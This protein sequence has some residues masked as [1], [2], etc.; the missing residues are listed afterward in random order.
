MM[1]QFYRAIA[2]VLLISSVEANA[3]VVPSEY[4][5]GLQALD[6][7]QFSLALHH[8]YT[9]KLQQQHRLALKAN[10]IENEVLNRFIQ[11]AESKISEIEIADKLHS[12]EKGPRK[13][14]AQTTE[15]DTTEKRKINF[16][17]GLDFSKLYR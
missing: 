8:F 15:T 5:L 11:F 13:V 7:S 2:I 1:N 14:D 10:A 4:D 16:K 6:K 12:D 17:W 3:E 9:Y